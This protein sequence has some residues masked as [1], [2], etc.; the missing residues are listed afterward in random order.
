MRAVDRKGLALAVNAAAYTNVDQAESE[1]D[2][3][4]RVNAFGAATIAKA[5]ADAELPLIHISSD[6]VFDGSKSSAYNEHDPIF[7][8]G[9]Y[10]RSKAEGELA[11]RQLNPRH[12]ILRTAWLY[13]VYR[14]NFVK[15]ILR[16]GAER[17]ELRVVA[18]QRGS[19]TSTTD[20]ADAIIRV[21]SR[22]GSVPWGTYHFTGTGDTTW[23]GFASHIVE[24][25]AFFTGRRPLVKAI[26]TADFPSKARRPQNSVLD[27]T[28]FAA[29]FGFRAESWE[30][31][32]NRTVAELLNQV[33]Q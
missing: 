25:Q 20:L 11:V 31:A 10:G 22:L 9:V 26:K 19:P 3:A 27:S 1:P 16:L 23:H 5:C 13:G 14:Q 24:A 6:Y 32:V 12:L 7:P 29:T 15:T 28:R 30:P 8:L 21:R 17:D 2:P 33:K 4:F 18:D